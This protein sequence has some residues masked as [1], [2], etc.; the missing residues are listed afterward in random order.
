MINATFLSLSIFI[1]IMTVY[2]IVYGIYKKKKEPTTNRLIREYEDADD[3]VKKQKAG[4]LNNLEK[5][6]LSARLNIDTRAFV[7]II[8]VLSIV[9]YIGAYYVFEQPLVSFAPLPFSLYFLPRAVIEYKK[10][11]EEDKFDAELIQILR[12][13]SSTLKN[14]SVLQALEDVKDLPSL[15]EKSRTLLNEIFHRYKYGES[16]ESAFYKVAESSGSEQFVLCA[17]SIDINKELG[18]DL[19]ESINKIAL[20]IQRQ[21]LTEKEGKSLMSQ[22]VMIGRIMSVAPFGIMGYMMLQNKDYFSEYL[23]TVGHQLIFV[24]LFM[25]MFFGVYIV[26]KMSR[27]L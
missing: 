12:R 3:S 20:N 14:G 10:N 22:T 11:K 27:T 5:D 24:G 17:R 13:M 1:A 6:L 2:V 16:I 19:S 26:D 15:S 18:A 25:V 7:I 8:L 23:E 4:F 21:R 9:S